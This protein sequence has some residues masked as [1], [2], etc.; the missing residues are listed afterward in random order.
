M[1]S[2]IG[3]LLPLLCSLLTPKTSK[4]KSKKVGSINIIVVIGCIATKE[5]N[6]N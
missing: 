2:L 4:V 5:L 3:D 1:F 6:L